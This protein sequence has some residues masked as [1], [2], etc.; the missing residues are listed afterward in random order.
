MNLGI[1]GTGLAMV[2]TNFTIL[3]FNVTYT[4]FIKDIE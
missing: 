4:Y 1:L 3:A 2:I